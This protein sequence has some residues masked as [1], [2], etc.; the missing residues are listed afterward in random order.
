MMIIIKDMYHVHTV[1]RTCQKPHTE[2]NGLSKTNVLGSRHWSDRNNVLIQPWFLFYL[3]AN[4]RS[5][6]GEGG[7]GDQVLLACVHV[8]DPKKAAALLFVL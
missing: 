5:R 8:N 3:C 1:L 2:K 6:E 4:K 7:G